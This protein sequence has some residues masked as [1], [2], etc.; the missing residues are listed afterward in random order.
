[1]SDIIKLHEDMKKKLYEKIDN[2][3]CRITVTTNIWTSDS[4]IFAYACLTTHCID[5]EWELQKI[6][7]NYKWIVWTHDGESLFRFISQLIM[8]WNLDKK[9][10]SMIV[11]HASINDNMVRH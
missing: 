6:I 8:E 5:N 4:Q 1:M 3:G 7:L 2:M 10:F 11:D 9:L